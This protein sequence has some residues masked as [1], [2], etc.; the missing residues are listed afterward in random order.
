MHDLPHVTTVIKAAGL[1]GDM[2]FIPEGAM[3]IGT[4]THK[5]TELLDRGCLDMGS[6]IPA[7]AVRL[8]SYQKFLDEVKPEIVAAELRVE[9]KALGY[10]GTLDRIVVINGRAAI[11]D[12]KGVMASDWHGLQLSAYLMAASEMELLVDVGDG[13][14]DTARFNLYLR[15]DGYKLVERTRNDAWPAFVACLNL[16]RW[17]QNHGD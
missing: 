2:S 3:Q 10:C 5:A 8:A 1:M 16:F 14:K 13:D 15:D 9:S 4:A 6:L 7:V 17:R 11:L 12:I